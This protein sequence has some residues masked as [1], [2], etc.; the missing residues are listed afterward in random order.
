MLLLDVTKVM[1]LA[2]AAVVALVGCP[3]SLENP[4]RFSQNATAAR[5]GAACDAPKLIASK[6]GACHGGPKPLGGLALDT[7]AALDAMIDRAAIGGAGKLVDPNAPAASV[8]LTKLE[9]PAPFGAPMPPSGSLPDAERQCIVSWVNGK[10]APGAP[11]AGAPTP[12]QPTTTTTVPIFLAIGYEGRTTISCDDG[13][14]WTANRSDDDALRCF[15]P[16]DCDHDG[17]AGRGVAFLNGFFVANFGWGAP[18]TIRRSRDGVTWDTV[19]TGDNFASM[20]T[21]GTRLVAISGAPKISADDGATWIDGATTGTGARRGGFAAGRFLLVDDGPRAAL[22]TDG[23]GWSDVTTWPSDCGNDIQW[24]GGIAQAGE[25]TIVVASGDGVVCSSSDRG[26]TWSSRK[27]ADAI[28]GRL[29][30]AGSDVVVWGRAAG[31]TPSVFRSSN[32]VDWT[33]TPT[34]LR[35]AGEGPPIGP[36][37]VS[38]N[39]TYVAANDGWDVWYEQQRFYRSTDG[40]TWDALAAGAFVGSHPITHITWA[41]GAPSAACPLE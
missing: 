13:A 7:P 28:G 32:G 31:G 2:V 9:T 11:L 4:E 6:C 27:I 39:G 15:D 26:A 34:I 40:V 21:D 3:G 22:S 23:S 17:K 37:A 14:T 1:P 29:L 18:G 30:R 35:G 12:S 38:A 16:T 10:A 5:P 33:T 36:V 24:S 19:A 41:E 8:L 25:S 20:T